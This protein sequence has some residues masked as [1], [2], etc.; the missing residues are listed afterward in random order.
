MSFWIVPRSLLGRHALLLRGG[1][2]EAPQ[3]DRRPVDR[4]RRRDLVERDAVEQHL[5]VGQ[6]R[7]GHAALAHLAQRPRMVGVVAHQRREVER[8]RQPGLAVLEQE[9]EARVG[10]L[11]AAEAG[12]LAHR[13]QLAAVAGGMDAARERIRRRA[14]RGRC[15]PVAVDVERRVQRRHLRAPSS[16]RRCRAS[17]RARTA[18]A[19]RPLRRAA[20]RAR[21]RCSAIV[22]REVSRRRHRRHSA[23]EGLHCA[24]AA[25]RRRRT[26]CVRP[27]SSARQLLVEPRVGRG[28][29]PQPAAHARTRRRPRPARAAG[30]RRRCRSVAARLKITKVPVERGEQ[31]GDPLALSRHRAQHRRRPRSLGR[32]APRAPPAASASADS[33]ARRGPRRGAPA[34][35]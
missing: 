20:A 27:A 21:P 12:E 29:V 25:R 15:S 18:R 1:D 31:V 14:R 28:V 5:H 13:P 26:G 2:V 9:L 19:T 7:D 17:R 32:P 4:H 24:P 23:S 10:L 16:R 11:G 34:R 22:S 33:H 30:A 6:A 35:S 3:D 8:H